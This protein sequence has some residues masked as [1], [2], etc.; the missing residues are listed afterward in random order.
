M[1]KLLMTDE[2]IAKRYLNDEPIIDLANQNKCCPETI[3]VR[4]KRAEVYNKRRSIGKRREN[5]KHQEFGHLKVIE[6]APNSPGGRTQW[7]CQCRCGNQK[8]VKANYLKRKWT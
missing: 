4:L 7:L 2:E 5:L 6:R 1:L 8:I 3:I